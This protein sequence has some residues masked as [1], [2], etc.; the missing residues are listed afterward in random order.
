MLPRLRDCLLCTYLMV[1]FTRGASD[2]NV[3]SKITCP[4][5]QE[6]KKRIRAFEAKMAKL[7]RKR[8]R[9]SLL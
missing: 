1:M 3:F 6:R 2:T 9:G 5:L 8:A 4:P 7:E